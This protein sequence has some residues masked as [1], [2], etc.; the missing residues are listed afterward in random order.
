MSNALPSGKTIG[1][2]ERAQ[3]SCTDRFPLPQKKKYKTYFLFSVSVLRLFSR[4]LF[5]ARL[6]SVPCVDLKLRVSRFL[7]GIFRCFNLRLSR[8]WLPFCLFCCIFFSRGRTEVGGGEVGGGV[9]LCDRICD[10]ISQSRK[11]W[12]K[13]K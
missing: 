5:L 1:K 9:R 10:G 8:I 6:S 4:A 7:F 11:R 3:M 13:F 12:T 2:D